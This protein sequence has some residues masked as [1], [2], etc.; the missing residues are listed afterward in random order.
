[1]PPS[2]AE[3][4]FNRLEEL[5]IIVGDHL[6]SSD[7]FKLAQ[8]EGV[9]ICDTCGIEFPSKEAIREHQVGFCGSGTW[10]WRIRPKESEVEDADMDT[11]LDPDYIYIY[12]NGLNV[13]RYSQ[14]SISIF[15]PRTD[16]ELGESDEY[17]EQL[18]IKTLN[19]Q[20][21]QYTINFD[22]QSEGINGILWRSRNGGSYN[23]W[24]NWEW[25]GRGNVTVIE[26]VG[27]IFAHI[28]RK[29]IKGNWSRMTEGKDYQVYKIHI[30]SGSSAPIRALN[31][32]RRGIQ[33]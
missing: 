24:E 13:N 3:L 19:E 32:A 27:N 28:N 9:V 18:R 33:L 10:T 15:S 22:A 2:K 8:S 12:W 4:I 1:M 16:I 20:L 21:E 26:V 6:F 5:G 23:T 29:P 17:Y 7:G 25:L 11:I 31:Y 14:S 30:F